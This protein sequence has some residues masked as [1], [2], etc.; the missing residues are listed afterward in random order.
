MTQNKTI[1]SNYRQ[2]FKKKTDMALSRFDN[3]LSDVSQ[4]PGGAA[5]ALV[6]GNPG[7]GPLAKRL[8]MD[9]DI[10]EGEAL[11]LIQL[12]AET[13]YLIDKVVR[14]KARTGPIGVDNSEVVNLEVEGEFKKKSH[15][16]FKLN[17]KTEDREEIEN[18]GYVDEEGVYH[19]LDQ[20][21]KLF[22]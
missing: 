21:E 5:N 18:R 12:P 13:L 4:M 11:G 15:H 7:L 2:A 10:D 8:M 16:I 22:R 17:N 19:G 20:D 14:Q 9:P 3:E 1:M 6:A